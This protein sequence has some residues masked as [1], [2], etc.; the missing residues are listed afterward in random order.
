MGKKVPIPHDQLTRIENK[1]SL[2]ARMAYVKWCLDFFERQYRW[3]VKVTGRKDAIRTRSIRFFK[4]VLGR[5]DTTI[6]FRYRNWV[7]HRP[8]EGWT[9]YVDR[10]GMALQVPLMA[11]PEQAW[12]AF[13][14]FRSHINTYFENRSS[15]G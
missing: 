6:T 3:D 13:Q 8:N 7:W 5:Q 9:L 15:H 4:A 2:W 14:K 10:R 12:E 1:M 11:T